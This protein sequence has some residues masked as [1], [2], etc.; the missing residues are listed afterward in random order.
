MGK[1]RKP[2]KPREKP[3]QEQETPIAERKDAS[4]HK[5][6]DPR[7]IIQPQ[8]EWHSVPLPSL[9]NPDAD[10]STSPHVLQRVH[11]YAKAL[12]DAES[13]SYERNH[14]Q[15]SSSWKF[16]STVISTG[17]WND[18]VSARTLLVQESPLHM[19]KQ[20]QELLGM[21]GTK[22]RNQALMALEAAKDMLCQG[23]VLPS[24]RK[25]RFFMKQPQLLA[26]FHKVNSWNED[27]PLPNGIEKGH[28]IQWAYEDWLKHTYFEVLKILENW[29]GDEVEFARKRSVTYAFELLKEKPEQDE[30]L[31]RLI[32]NKLGDTTKKVASDASHLLLKLQDFHPPMKAR[33]IGVIETETL[34]KPGQSSHAK[35]YAVITL[36]QTVIK[37]PEIANK[38]LDIY[39]TI[40]VSILNRSK[41]EKTSAEQVT[42]KHPQDPK[43]NKSKKR[44]RGGGTPND[45]ETTPEREMDDKIIAQVLTGVNRALPFA[46]TDGAVFD[47]HLDTLFRITHSANFNT[48][49]QALIL[50]RQIS[51][52]H[53]IST[54]RFMRTLYESLLDPRLLRSSKQTMYLNLLY[55][56][57]KDDP[58]VR[59]V[60][61][62]VKRLMQI[63]FLHEPPFTVGVLYMIQQLQRHFPGLRA[64]L[65]TPEITDEDDEEEV[66]K[67]APDADDPRTIGIAGAQQDT[68]KQKQQDAYDPRKR[69]PEH[70]N[71]ERTCLWELSPWLQHYHPSI[72]LFAQSL[73]KPDA[74]LDEPKPET[75]T[76]THFLERFSYRSNPKTKHLSTENNDSTDTPNVSAKGVPLRG[77]SFMQPALASS[78]RVDILLGNKHPSAKLASATGANAVT[79]PTKTTAASSAGGAMMSTSATPVPVN[80]ENFWQ[81]RADEVAPDEVFFHRYFKAVGPRKKAAKE[82][83]AQKDDGGPP[84]Q[85]KKKRKAG[86]ADDGEFDEDIGMDEGEIWNALVASRP[87]LEDGDVDGGDGGVDLD[88]VD[89]EDIAEADY[90]DDDDDDEEEGDVDD[91]DGAE[92]ADA[93]ADAEDGGMSDAG[94]ELNLESDPDSDS[95]G[96]IDVD[97]DGEGATN[98]PPTA[99]Q[100]SKGG[101]VNGAPPPA[102]S[103]GK[104]KKKNEERSEKR[105]KLKDLGDFASME[106]V[107]RLMGGGT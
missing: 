55:G 88:D 106:D 22:S 24:D 57:L 99:K 13:H 67:D 80:S 102:E 14:L 98:K 51:S 100:T 53:N 61:A 12:L 16:T 73:F 85:E 27:A 97:L 59:R 41:N 56:A 95:S 94:V 6:K 9:P 82:K 71:A 104:N 34:L 21:A 45:E 17:T 44:K 70:S 46:V 49:I 5:K 91:V 50:I 37:S 89:E 92:A 11:D 19:R 81:Q 101:K 90:S 18:R 84:H 62:F 29:C 83:R 33:I 74:R 39:F 105:R 2:A 48:S 4:A 35:Y 15:R 23:V 64:M 66:F 10:S 38:L 68:R 78:N 30:N 36:N 54:D 69:D 93:D 52:T 26:A 3:V 72:T 76:L 8:P 40:F 60:K 1:H 25:L 47:K 28:L 86:D 107:E 103:K 7:L 20:F 96:D 58:S 65:D 79:G 87:E 77:S 75:H 43:G 63:V 32:V 31:L 42:A